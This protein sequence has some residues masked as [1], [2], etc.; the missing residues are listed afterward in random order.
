MPLGG[1]NGSKW[2]K[3]SPKEFYDKE[4][5]DIKRRIVGQR[6]IERKRRVERRRGR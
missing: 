5:Y 3:R 4:D 6:K 1:R 2:E